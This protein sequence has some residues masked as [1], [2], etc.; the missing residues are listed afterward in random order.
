MIDV[1][2]LVPG[3]VDVHARFHPRGAATLIPPHVTVLFPFVPP[4]ELADSVDVVRS[5]AARFAPI[6]VVLGAVTSFASKRVVYARVESPALR[7]L[8]RTVHHAFPDTPPYG[9]VFDEVVP[10]LTLGETGRHERDGDALRDAV[11]SATTSLL[12]TTITVTELQIWAEH[13]RNR[14]SLRHALQLGG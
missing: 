8:L 5:I 2:A 6:D 7:E 4:H 11:S 9:G 14:W 1:G 3:L 10:H 12:P 13:E